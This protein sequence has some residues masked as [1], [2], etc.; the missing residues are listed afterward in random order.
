MHCTETLQNIITHYTSPIYITALLAYNRHKGPTTLT[1][2][3][4][5]IDMSYKQGRKDNRNNH[6][7]LKIGPTAHIFQRPFLRSLLVEGLILGGLMYRG[8]FS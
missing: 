7:I 1:K 8:K 4:P 3:Q 5:Y 6:K 2:L